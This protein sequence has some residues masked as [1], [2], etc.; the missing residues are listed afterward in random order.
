LGIPTGY[1]IRDRRSAEG[2]RRIFQSEPDTEEAGCTRGDR[3][4]IS[5]L[6]GNAVSPGICVVCGYLLSS[7]S[8]LASL[9]GRPP[10]IQAGSLCYFAKRPRQSGLFLVLPL[11]SEWQPSKKQFRDEATCRIRLVMKEVREAISK[12]LDLKLSPPSSKKAN[13]P[14]TETGSWWGSS[15]FTLS[16]VFDSVR[17]VRSF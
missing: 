12:V 14:M 9:G 17:C 7:V 3:A 6:E 10:K 16:L 13:S 1:S 15:D 5:E 2:R 11:M 8:G 4:C